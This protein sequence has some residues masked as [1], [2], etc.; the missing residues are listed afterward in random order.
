[1]E[2]KAEAMPPSQAPS[3]HPHHIKFHDNPFSSS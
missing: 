3:I 2:P 1:V